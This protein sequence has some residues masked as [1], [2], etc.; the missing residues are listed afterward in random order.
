MEKL[1]SEIEAYSAEAGIK[2]QKLLRDAIDAGWGQWA[3]WKAGR[4]SPTMA[5]V[6]RV[7]GY[8]S[9][10]PPEGYHARKRGAAA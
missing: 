4:S 5:V 2:P 1:I 7:C 3:G 6:D 9:I 8:M 10:H